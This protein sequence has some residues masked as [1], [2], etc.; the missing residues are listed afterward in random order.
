MHGNEN[1][2]QVVTRDQQ[3]KL[4]KSRKD[5]RKQGQAS[6]KPK[7]GKGKGAG[8]GVKGRK[9]GK[10]SKRGRGGKRA[11]LGKKRSA[12]EEEPKA[13]R[14]GKRAKPADLEESA[15][16]T[17]KRRSKAIKSEGHPK[18]KAKAKAK[19]R[20]TTAPAP[21]EEPKDSNSTPALK[22]K[23]R[24][25]RKVVV[26]DAELLKNSPLYR[27]SLVQELYDFALKFDKKA[28]VRTSSY[29]SQMKSECPELA[30]Y[31]L[32]LY[33]TRC[34]CG[35]F[36]KHLGKDLYSFSVGSN[37]YE[38]HKCAVSAMCA[39]VAAAC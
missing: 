28:N 37:A 36:S 7:G 19:G 6:K 21:P 23:A 3:L 2:V 16:V 38:A 26:D 8:K 29:K 30:D 11:L 34:A 22:A 25:R 33:W 9:G 18:A 27:A 14:K 39:M 12:P 31:R 1:E 10:R 4:K 17:R 13:A 35:I 32:N 20:K 24:G 5:T 15:P